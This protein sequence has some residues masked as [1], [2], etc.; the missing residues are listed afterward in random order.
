MPIHLK[1]SSCELDATF[2][3]AQIV[4]S[5]NTCTQKMVSVV[6]AVSST[7]DTYQKEIKM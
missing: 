3:T 4:W 1:H 5:K 7:T 2:D 6:S